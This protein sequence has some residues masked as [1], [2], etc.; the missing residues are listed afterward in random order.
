[1][2]KQLQRLK[3]KAP[4]SGSG[5]DPGQ[6]ADRL[7]KLQQDARALANTTDTMEKALE[8]KTTT[9]QVCL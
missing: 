6:L 8:G 1:M 3:D 7:A 9:P 2:E 4:A 5:G